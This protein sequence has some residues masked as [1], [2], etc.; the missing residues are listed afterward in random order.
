MINI[1]TPLYKKI[2]L[3]NYYLL[4]AVTLFASQQAFCVTAD[5]TTLKVEVAS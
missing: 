2:E 1:P 4:H 3:A 5:F